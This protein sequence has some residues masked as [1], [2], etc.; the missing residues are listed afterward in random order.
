MRVLK[1]LYV[2]FLSSI[3]VC[4]C[5]CVCVVFSCSR[6]SSIHACMHTSVQIRWVR[7]NVWEGIAFVRVSDYCV[8]HAHTHLQREHVRT[9]DLGAHIHTP[10]R[11]QS[12]EMVQERRYIKACV[13]L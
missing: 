12:Y 2:W 1:H 4:V 6:E 7:M 10:I 5:V 3:C 11:I 8:S 13:H 9:R